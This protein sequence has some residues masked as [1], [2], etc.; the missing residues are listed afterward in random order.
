MLIVGDFMPARRILFCS[1]LYAQDLLALCQNKLSGKN[2]L[3]MDFFAD[4]K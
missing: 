1:I 4:R 2:K 3:A